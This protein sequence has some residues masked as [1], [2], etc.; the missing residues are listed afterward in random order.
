MLD[1]LRLRL[2]LAGETSLSGGNLAARICGQ[3]LA[4]Q[5]IHFIR[6]LL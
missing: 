3:I 4:G 2:S 5:F 6:E 1:I